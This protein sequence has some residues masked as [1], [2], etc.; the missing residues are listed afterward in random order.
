MRD[1][2]G[3]VSRYAAISTE[4]TEYFLSKCSEILVDGFCVNEGLRLE[5]KG[6]KTLNSTDFP[7]LDRPNLSNSSKARKMEQNGSIEEA[8]IMV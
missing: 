3:A 1:V 4:W 6:A 2:G 5:N 8:K 7:I